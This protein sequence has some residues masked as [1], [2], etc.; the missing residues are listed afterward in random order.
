MDSPIDLSKYTNKG[1][2][3]VTRGG[4]VAGGGG[5][6]EGHHHPDRSPMTPIGGVRSPSLASL[7]LLTRLSCLSLA[8]ALS[9]LYVR[10]V[11]HDDGDNCNGNGKATAQHHDNTTTRRRCD[12][13]FQPTMRGEANGNP[14]LAVLLCQTNP[15][16]RL[17]THPRHVK[18]A[19][20]RQDYRSRSKIASERDERKE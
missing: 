15:D 2:L 12:L 14:T 4:S 7:S 1:K 6:A 13:V 18:I 20:S 11:Q 3:K 16:H 17:T 8:P 10:Q 9:L 5:L 19:I